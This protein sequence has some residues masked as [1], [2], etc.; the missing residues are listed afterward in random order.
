MSATRTLPLGDDVILQH[1]ADAVTALDADGRLVYANDA[2]RRMFG[3][4][5]DDPLFGDPEALVA[6]FELYDLEGRT[7]AA[8]ALPSRR[9]LR[10][11]AEARAIIRWRRRGAART[12]DERWTEVQARPVR[13]AAGAVQ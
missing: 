1:I 8:E 6:A 4:T 2:A 13:D 7:L 11:E 10:G 5:V 12:E 3:I 9:V